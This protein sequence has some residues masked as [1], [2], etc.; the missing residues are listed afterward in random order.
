[1]LAGEFCVV[2]S[3]RILRSPMRNEHSAL[4]FQPFNVLTFLQENAGEKV[5]IL[6]PKVFLRLLNLFEIIFRQE[7]STA[8]QWK[9]AGAKVT[10]GN[11]KTSA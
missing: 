5:K 8:L 6:I 7:T 2:N 1:M 4:R 3:Q 9:T 11:L 10:E